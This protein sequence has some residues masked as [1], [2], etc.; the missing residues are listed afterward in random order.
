MGESGSWFLLE[1]VQSLSSLSKTWDWTLRVSSWERHSNFC[2][3]LPHRR[4]LLPVRVKVS[5]RVT[6]RWWPRGGTDVSDDLVST[7][8]SVH[9]QKKFLSL[10]WTCFHFRC[11]LFLCSNAGEFNSCDTVASNFVVIYACVQLQKNWIC[12][13]KLH[14]LPMCFILLFNCGKIQFV[15]YSCL[16][17]PLCRTR[18]SPK[19]L[20]TGRLERELQ[21][22]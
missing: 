15:W 2:G 21:M 6:N 17:I 13:I 3:W 5:C 22:V 4:H 7:S 16:L 18:V 10:S 20:R 12:V 1:A 11:V 19:S 9:L 14:L 8:V